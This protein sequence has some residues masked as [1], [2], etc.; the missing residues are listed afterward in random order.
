MDAVG[1]RGSGRELS[2]RGEDAIDVTKAGKRRDV[3]VRT[4]LERQEE[5][6]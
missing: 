2:K 5:K 1:G 6:A 4:R 3:L